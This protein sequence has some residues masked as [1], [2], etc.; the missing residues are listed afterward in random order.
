MQRLFL[1]LPSLGERHLLLRELDGHA[2]LLAEPDDPHAIAGLL[3]RVVAGPAGEA[4]DLAT[5]YPSWRDRVLAALFVREFGNRIDSEGDCTACGSA[6]A[7]AFGLDAILA[8]QD[9]TAAASGLTLDNGIWQLEHGWVRPPHM[10][11]LAARE[12]VHSD[13]VSVER[14]EELLEA[15]APL[16]AIDIEATCP[17]CD[18]RPVIAFEIGDYLLRCLA[19]ERP[20]LLRETHLIASS[21]GWSH[22]AIL[23]LPRGD[24]RAFAHLIVGER[25]AVSLRRA[26]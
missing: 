21:Y 11:D 1:S 23:A 6:F 5:L 16:L 4:V 10:A 24:R 9:E 15:G 2:E 26:G 17:H 12:S 7:F 14:A 19:G 25:S 3:A 18:A 13:E 22:D 20:L 8:E